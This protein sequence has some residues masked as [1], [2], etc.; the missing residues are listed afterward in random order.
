M[1]RCFKLRG[2]ILLLW[3]S[4]STKVLVELLGGGLSVPVVI[5]NQEKNK[6]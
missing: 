6:T 3:D 2:R 5:V 4:S 1:L